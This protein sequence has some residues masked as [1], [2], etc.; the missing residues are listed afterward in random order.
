M[1]KDRRRDF[2]KGAGVAAAAVAGTAAGSLAA[3]GKADAQSSVKVNP[4]ARA[5]MPNGAQMSRPQVL[6]QLG[7]DPSTPPDAWLAVTVCGLNASAL[8]ERQ[9]QTLDSKGQL[10]LNAQDLRSLEKLR[11]IQL[12]R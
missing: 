9:L 4:N 11:D 2:L 12:K 10:K 7:L 6:R 3:A 5:V 1:S 8:T